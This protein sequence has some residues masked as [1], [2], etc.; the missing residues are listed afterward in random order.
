MAVFSDIEKIYNI[1]SAIIH[2]T[3]YIAKYYAG[4]NIRVNALSLGEL[5]DSQPESFFRIMQV[6][7]LIRGC[8]ILVT[9]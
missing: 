6:I 3:K 5:F 4:Y 2:L 1:K 9:L 8:L 7:V